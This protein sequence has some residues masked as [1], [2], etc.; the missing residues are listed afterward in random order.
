MG[1]RVMMTFTLQATLIVSIHVKAQT[2]ADSEQKLREALAS[3][4]A[5]LG[6]LNDEPIVVAFEIEGDLDL[7]D[8]VECAGSIRTPHAA[9]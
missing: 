1:P 5:N 9:P 2:R 7:L 3:S 4:C 8:V 6:M